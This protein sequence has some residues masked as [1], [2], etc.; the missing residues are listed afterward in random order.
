MTSL[1]IVVMGGAGA[2]GRIAVRDLVETAPD[3]IRIV[4]ADFNEAGARKLAKTFG[5][6][7]VAGVGADANDVR[8]TAKMLAGAFA[9]INCTQHAFNRKVM[10]AAL[11]AGAH[12]TDL[13]GLFHMT[14]AQLALHA[15]FEKAG[16]LALLGMGAAPGITNVLARSA[17]DTMD[18]VHE[19][20]TLVGTV[21][22][23]PNRPVTPMGVS[24]SIQTIMDEASLPAALFTGGKMT[25]VEPM[26]GAVAVHLPEPVG[27]RRPA[28]TIH[29]E[30]ATL[31]YSYAQKG[32]REVS[33]KIAFSEAL[34][35]RL[36]FLRAIHMLSDAPVQVGKAKVAPRAVLLKALSEM[37]P[38]AFDG[39]PDEYEIVRAI[40]RG[41]RAEQKVE[42]TV[43]CHV[44]G[45]P[46][47]GFGVDV[48]TGCPP[49]IAVQMLLRGEIT[50]R[51]CLPPERAVP[52]EPFFRELLRRAMTVRRSVVV[53]AGQ[54]RPGR[55]RSKR[56]GK[57]NSEART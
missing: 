57:S 13:G 7:G 25:F 29:S 45:I 48:D 37:K 30:V 19:I 20:H 5:R 46:S 50:A 35:D 34:D 40:V 31:P 49:S 23:T 39:I 36:R 28:Y 53:T 26:S 54:K 9:V 42:E 10:Q 3:D 14:K 27:V 6:K 38:V 56:R 55:A 15:K 11:S 52:C 2:M 18:E 1:T 16:L 51:G 24:Y 43:D 8:G 17:A 44:P 21:D 41:V 32:V 47:W 33:F 12:Y 22:R 4:I